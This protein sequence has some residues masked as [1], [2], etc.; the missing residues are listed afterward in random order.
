MSPVRLIVA[1]ILHC[2]FTSSYFPP[3]TRVLIIEGRRPIQKYGP[4]ISHVSIQLP[5]N[6]LDSFYTQY[7]PVLYEYSMSIA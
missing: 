7:I 4:I 3:E 2:P 5:I 6:Q 1:M